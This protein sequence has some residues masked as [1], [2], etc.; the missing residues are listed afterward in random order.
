MTGDTGN[1]FARCRMSIEVTHVDRFFKSHTYWGV[2]SDAEVSQRAI[3]ERVLPASVRKPFL[4]S[5][6]A[7]APAA[8]SGLPSI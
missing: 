3:V 1:P 2:T 4:L 5:I 6:F 8:G 7:I